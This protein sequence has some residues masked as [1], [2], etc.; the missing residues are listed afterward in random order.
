MA[1]NGRGHIEVQSR[2]TRIP[3]D[4]GKRVPARKLDVP[5]S[6]RTRKLTDARQYATTAFNTFGLPAC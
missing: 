2:N 5:A 6:I 4:R 1:E 3:W